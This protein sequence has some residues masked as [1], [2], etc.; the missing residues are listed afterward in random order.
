MANEIKAGAITFE[1]SDYEGY[2]FNETTRFKASG[3]VFEM[4]NEDAFYPDVII[5]RGGGALFEE[6]SSELL[7]IITRRW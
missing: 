5:V 6:E 7:T 4:T 1:Q 3:V 2:S